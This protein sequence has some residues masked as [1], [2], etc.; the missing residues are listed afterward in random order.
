LLAVVT[1][2]PGPVDAYQQVLAGPF[3][4]RGPITCGVGGQEF[5]S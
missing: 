5:Q 1:L 2:V 4:F 3:D